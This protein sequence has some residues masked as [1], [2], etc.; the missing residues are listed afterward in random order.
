MQDQRLP[1]VPFVDEKLVAPYSD[2]AR[3]LLRQLYLHERSARERVL[4]TPPASPA[5]ALSMH[6]LYDGTWRY[7]GQLD[8]L[9]RRPEYQSGHQDRAKDIAAIA[10]L[11][12]PGRAFEFG[13]GGGSL[14][15]A[16]AAAGWRVE[17]LDLV[18]GADWPAIAAD[19]GVT[20]HTGEFATFEVDRDAFD[21]V[22]ADNSL[23]HIPPG[24]YELV[25]TKVFGMLKRD[26]WFIA[27]VPNSLTGPHDVT[28]YFVRRGRPAEGSHF[29]ERRFAD[30]AAD[31]RQAGFNRLTTT[32]YA[33]LAA[34]RRFGWSSL[35]YW[36]AR[37]AEAVFAMLPPSLRVQP[38]FDYCVPS[39]IAAQKT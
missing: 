27:M 26:G 32:A 21:L 7:C 20:F 4:A 22:I 24:D 39:V 5:R 34:A 13:A 14:C 31:L 28:Q 36:K 33:G 19:H 25:L 10:R 23:E 8:V 18:P 2:E 35:W 29:N 15:L 6:E 3:A 17:G 12:E 9:M 38:F 37:L 1:T 30:L 16:L 11:R